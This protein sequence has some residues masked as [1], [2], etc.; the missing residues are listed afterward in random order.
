MRGDTRLKRHFSS[1]FL[2]SNHKIRAA[3][4]GFICISP[5]LQVRKAGEV[6]TRAILELEVLKWSSSSAYRSHDGPICRHRNFKAIRSRASRTS[7]S[8]SAISKATS[9][10]FTALLKVPNVMVP[11]IL[12]WQPRGSRSV[13]TAR[14]RSS[15]TVDLLQYQIRSSIIIP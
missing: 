9:R 10:E 11:I 3:L 13:R 2:D 5:K 1:H 7:C 8:R 15:V 4:V 14:E 12:R 6:E